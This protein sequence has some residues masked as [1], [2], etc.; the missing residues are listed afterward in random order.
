MARQMARTHRTRIMWY[1]KT[2]STL[3]KLELDISI[4]DFEKGDFT[5]E[6]EMFWTKD[7]DLTDGKE[8]FGSFELDPT[9]HSQL[10]PAALHHSPRSKVWKRAPRVLLLLSARSTISA[11]SATSPPSPS[12]SL[13]RPLASPLRTSRYVRSNSSPTQPLHS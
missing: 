5:T 11:I 10:C 4:I 2:R 9:A 7:C 12:S 13:L 3:A 6:E 8:Y 1:T